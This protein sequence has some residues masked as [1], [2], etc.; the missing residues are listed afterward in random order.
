MRLSNAGD[1]PAVVV[2]QLATA[3]GD[4]SLRVARAA[5]AANCL[6]AREFGGVVPLPWSRPRRA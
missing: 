6:S 4:G 5:R 1:R 3:L 2:P